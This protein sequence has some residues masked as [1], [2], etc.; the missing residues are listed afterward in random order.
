MELR[1]IEQTHRSKKGFLLQKT[2]SSWQPVHRK[3]RGLTVDLLN[4]PNSPNSLPSIFDSLPLLQGDLSYC[5]TRYY[6]PLKWPR[7]W[8][9]WQECSCSTFWSFLN[10]LLKNWRTSVYWICIPSLKLRQEWCCLKR[11]T[12]NNNN[13]TVD[14]LV[15]IF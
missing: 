9:L 12:L 1:W 14:S 6:L 5:L 11:R 3:R 10:S 13:F 8:I 4:F 2:D 15:H 7:G